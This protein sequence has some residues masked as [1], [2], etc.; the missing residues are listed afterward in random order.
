[1]CA[2]PLCCWLEIAI[3]GKVNILWSKDLLLEFVFFFSSFGW[4]I[5]VL[6]FKGGIF[7]IWLLMAVIFSVDRLGRMLSRRW[8]SRNRTLPPLEKWTAGARRYFVRVNA[9]LLILVVSGIWWLLVRDWLAAATVLGLLGLALFW[10]FRRDVR[11]WLVWWWAGLCLIA[12]ALQFLTA[13]AHFDAARVVAAQQIAAQPAFDVLVTPDGETYA[14]FRNAPAKKLVGGH[15]QEVDETVNPQ[16]MVYDPRTKKVFLVNHRSFPAQ[17]I[18]IVVVLQG[19]R[20]WRIPIDGINHGYPLIS[21]ATDKLFVLS[22]DGSVYVFD[23]ETLR[24]IFTQ[25]AGNDL[26]YADVDDR[27][28]R[29]YVATEFWDGRFR[30]MDTGTYAIVDG[31]W[32]GW[33]NLGVK[34]DDATGE[35]WIARTMGNE[36]L[37]L[38]PQLRPVAKI[39][40]GFQPRSVTID[41]ARGWVF[42]GNYTEGTVTIIDRATKKVLAT[43]RPTRGP[44]DRSWWR[45]FFVRLCGASVDGQGNLYVSDGYGIFRI[46]AAQ[47]DAAVRPATTPA[48]PANPP[49][50]SPPAAR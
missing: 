7:Y 4:A 33:F 16:C 37:V 17:R 48:T 45:A 29:L 13:Q 23:L 21:T 39:K 3:R 31:R 20:R 47:L 26:A 1:M 18:P 27:R 22:E 15:W 24:P 43:V 41:A 11:R 19:N 49:A 40:T 5:F 10:L 44:R 25:K 14:T 6:L 38:D 8:R 28:R 35:I 36:I 50:A 34:A 12:G 2:A 30:V 42:V 46:E 32:I 9:A